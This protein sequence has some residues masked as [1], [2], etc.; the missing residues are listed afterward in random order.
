[1]IKNNFISFLVFIFVWIFT[2]CFYPFDISTS[3]GFFVDTLMFFTGLSLYFIIGYLLLGKFIKDLNS[4]L[5]NLLS[6]SL[7]AVIS[8]CLYVFC[9][10]YVNINSFP[11]SLKWLIYYCFN[12]Y[13]RP[14][15]VLVSSDVSIWGWILDFQIMF[16]LIPAL[17]IWLGMEL[18]ILVRRSSMTENL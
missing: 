4:P 2:A 11:A 16:S 13:T 7:I 15:Y 18:K 17:L 10:I 3:Y 12:F 9:Q 8:L 6:V 1:M 14:L 5:K